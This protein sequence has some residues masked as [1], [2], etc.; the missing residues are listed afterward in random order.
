MTT[1]VPDEEIVSAAELGDIPRVVKLL[2]NG[3]DP[4]AHARNGATALM[5]AAWSCNYEL[6]TLLLKAYADPNIRDAGG[7]TP[8]MY[9]VSGPRFKS[10]YRTDPSR[11]DAQRTIAK[12][13]AEGA[14]ARLKDAKG[15]TALARLK[16]DR[17]AGIIDPR[18]PERADERRRRELIDRII[19]QLE[20]AEASPGIIVR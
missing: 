11:L 15:R 13:L 7:L 14:D 12:L 3:A 19:I 5:W 18:R 9:A 2:K 16:E 8:L 17:A 10:G 4:N 1:P 6:T 20:T